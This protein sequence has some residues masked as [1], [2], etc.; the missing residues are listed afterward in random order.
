VHLVG[1]TIKLFYNARS[2]ERQ[3]RHFLSTAGAVYHFGND[4]VLFYIKAYTHTH[5]HILSNM[6]RN[7]RKFYGDKFADKGFPGYYSVYSDKDVPWVDKSTCHD[8]GG[9]GLFRNVRVYIQDY[10]KSHQHIVM[11]RHPFVVPCSLLTWLS[12]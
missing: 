3:R 10:M 9:W 4:N 2:Y 12:V 8:D 5:I 7:V 6:Y 1:I 11:N